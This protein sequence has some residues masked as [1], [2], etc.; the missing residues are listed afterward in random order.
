[1]NTAVDAGLAP[2]QRS[3]SRAAYAF[4]ACLR[5][6]RSLRWR[7]WLVAA[8]AA[9][10]VGVL[11]AATYWF[12][13]VAF[14]K[15]NDGPSMLAVMM[16]RW[17]VLMTPVGCALAFGLALLRDIGRRGAI[18]PRHVTLTIVGVSFV[19]AVVDPI[20]VHLA[21]MVSAALRPTMKMFT[22]GSEDWLTALSRMYALSMDR[23]FVFA[24]TA[25]LSAVYFF[26][27]SRT[28]DA[29]AT[30][31]VGLSE[32]QRRAL[33]EELRSAQATVDPEFLFDTLADIDRRFESDANVAQRL[34]DALIRYLRAALP[35]NDDVVG[36]LGHQ[37][38]L[39]RAYLDIE[40]IR[41]AGRLQGQVDMPSELESRPFAPALVLPLVALAA[42]DSGE[43]GSDS[44]VK[45]RASVQGALLVIEVE[46]DVKQRG[47]TAERQSTLDSLRQRVSVLYGAEAELSYVVR[48]P[49]GSSARIAIADSG[50]P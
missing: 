49:F 14:T 47:L 48:E 17:L 20:G 35:A 23:V 11:T 24:S 44:H 12:G 43:A 1:V 8:G 22:S 31:Q 5:A 34:L 9:A 40:T 26:K 18:Q 4:R 29:L 41:S 3:E 28:S 45:V 37:A 16:T 2:A 10:L 7:H 50:N 13:E 32:A 36:T 30:A 21:T 33:G 19:G 46:S 39:V 25:T 42:S 6:W 38:V 15:A 27:I